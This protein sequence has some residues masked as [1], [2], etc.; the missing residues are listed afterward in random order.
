M[1]GSKEAGRPHWLV[2]KHD[3]GGMDVL[4]VN[5]GGSAEALAVFSVVEETRTFLDFRPGARGEEW[6]ARQT[7]P[8]E[9]TSI[10]YGP[11]SAVKKVALDPPLEALDEGKSVAFQ[12]MD[13]D[14]F[15]GQLLG[16]EPAG[17]RL[18]SSRTR[19]SHKGLPQN[20]VA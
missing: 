12:A 8:G 9:L 1:R 14:D 16:E 18:L 6:K 20:R 10:L 7:W 15:L 5:L 19:R 13:R 3:V 4:T 2:A 11:C 17:I